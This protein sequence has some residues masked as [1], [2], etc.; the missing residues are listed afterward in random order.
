MGESE[1]TAC[2]RHL[3]L[4]TKFVIFKN[5]WMWL[6][7][8]QI[9]GYYNFPMYLRIWLVSSTFLHWTRYDANMCPK[10]DTCPIQKGTRHK[11]HPIFN[12][13]KKEKKKYDIVVDVFQ[14]EHNNNK[15]YASVYI[16]MIITYS[17]L[18]THHIHTITWL[19]IVFLE[20]NFTILTEKCE[21]TF[22]QF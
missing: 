6:A 22:S 19:K 20:H 2:T 10:L 18:Y 5:F 11:L 7:L 3:C 14:L 1:Q 9:L 8:P 16:Y 4:K 13:I 17:L 15:C 12:T 21:L